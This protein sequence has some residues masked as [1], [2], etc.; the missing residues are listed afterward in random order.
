A[1][2]MELNSELGMMQ[3]IGEKEFDGL[4]IEEIKSKVKSYVEVLSEVRGTEVK[5][6]LSKNNGIIANINL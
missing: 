5:Y 2:F 6:M 3:N 1:M 4:T